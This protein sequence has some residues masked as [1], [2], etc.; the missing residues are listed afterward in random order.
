MKGGSTFFVEMSETASILRHATRHSLI[1]LDEL[2]RGTSTFDGTAIAYGVIHGLALE[3][4]ARTFFSTHYHCLVE[5]FS[6][7]PSVKASYMNSKEEGGKLI[8][9]Y[10]LTDGES[11]RSHG[12]HAARMA[13]MIEEV[14]C[15]AEKVANDMEKITRINKLM[16]SSCSRSIQGDREALRLASHMA[17]VN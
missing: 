7:N 14:V 8:F 17:V 3:T 11:P 16:A 4:K 15:E 12:F 13:G 9:L 5:S 6:S 2:G 1:L 10:K